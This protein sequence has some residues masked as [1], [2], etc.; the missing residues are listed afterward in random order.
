MLTHYMDTNFYLDALTGHSVT[1]IHHMTNATLIDWYTKKQATVETATNGLEFGAARTCIEQIVKLYNML[2]D[3]EDPADERS[4]MSGGIQF[5][6]KAT[7]IAH[8]NSI[9]SIQL[10]PSTMLKRQWHLNMLVNTLF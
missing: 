2:R 6:V 1:G 5:A 4:Y 8:G 3:M 10:Y 9:R 7:L